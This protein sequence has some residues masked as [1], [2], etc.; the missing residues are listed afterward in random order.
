MT[1]YSSMITRRGV[2]V[3]ITASGLTGCSHPNRLSA[4]SR[5]LDRPN[6]VYGIRNARFSPADRRALTEEGQS[7]LERETASLGRLGR[8]L[9]PAYYLAVSGG[10]DD[11]AF[12]AGLLVGWSQQGGR[13]D[14]K[15]VTG[16]STGALIAPFAF[17]G[18]GYDPALEAVYT[19]INQDNVL[20]QRSLLAAVTDDGLADTTPLFGLISHYVD[21]AMMA[22]IAREYDRGR[23][24]LIATTDLDHGRS[25]IWNI[26]AIAKSGRPEAKTLISRILLASAAI[27]GA[28]PPVMFDVE[29]AGQRYQELHVDGGAVAQTFLYPPTIS[30][31]G[32]GRTRTAFI[33][34]NSRLNVPFSET[35][36]QTLSIAGRAISTLITASGVGDIY[37]IYLTTRRDGVGFNLAY[38][39]SGFSEPYKSPF[40]QAY[41]TKLFNYGRDKARAGYP[42]RHQPPDYS[43]G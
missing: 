39:D 9:P 41:M 10:G 3:G 4:F 43:P 32:S 11:G 12:G 33:I 7:A 24:L 20:V 28:F 22:A 17:L 31:R 36:R 19:G 38:I 42:W 25:V 16:I 37:Q 18:R 13:P 14:F 15:L 2:L 21:D 40:D 1:M 23:L 6:E 26:G 29:V 35:K 34:R 8:P 27:P 5:P 30:T